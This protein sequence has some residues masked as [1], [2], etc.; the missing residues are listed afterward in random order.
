MSVLSSIDGLF[1]IVQP[2]LWLARAFPHCVL[3]LPISRIN[4]SCNCESPILNLKNHTFWL[5]S[6]PV[7]VL[8]FFSF[9]SVCPVPSQRK[10][11]ADS[12]FSVCSRSQAAK[13]PSQP[14]RTIHCSNNHSIAQD[15]EAGRRTTT[16]R[17]G[18]NRDASKKLARE[19]LDRLKRC[20]IEEPVVTDHDLA[21]KDDPC[22]C[23]EYVVDM[24]KHF[25]ELEVREREH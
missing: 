6:L 2:Q 24:Y 8:S 9:V 23:A 11:K 3:T 1:L 13:P 15:T 25:K 12:G 20:R 19:S 7:V 16:L 5:S 21:D 10:R 18:A 14:S 4:V 22:A 17:E